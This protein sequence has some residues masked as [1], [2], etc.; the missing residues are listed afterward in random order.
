MIVLFIDNINALSVE[1]F[2]YF[3]DKTKTEEAAAMF[4]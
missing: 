2:I 3:A 4:L 1:I